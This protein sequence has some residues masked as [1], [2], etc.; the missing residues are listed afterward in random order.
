MD[1]RPGRIIWTDLTVPNAPQCRDFYAEVVGW[2]AEEVSMGEYAD[3]NMADGD[4]EPVAGI[5][6][7]R[8]INAD[9]PPTWMM[10]VS[11]EDLDESLAAVR[12][13]RGSQLGP[14]REMGPW[15]TAIIMDPAGA[16]LTIGEFQGKVPAE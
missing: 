3:F 13:M 14:I 4:G 11:V 9:V 10:Y 12:R 16:M 5:C 2:R 8:G 15:R 7:A 6:H 1:A